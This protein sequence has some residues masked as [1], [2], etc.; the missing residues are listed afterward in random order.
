MDLRQRLAQWPKPFPRQKLGR[1]DFVQLFDVRIDCR[2]DNIPQCPLSQPFGERIDRQHLAGWRRFVGIEPLHARV[3]HFPAS[4]MQRRFTRQKHFLAAREFFQHVRLIEPKRTQIE[5]AV[6]HQHA[7]QRAAG[8]GVAQFAF[9]PR[10]R[11]PKAVCLA[12]D[13]RRYASRSGLDNRAGNKRARRRRC[14][15]RADAITPRAGP[16]PLRNCSGMRSVRGGAVA[17]GVPA[18]GISSTCGSTCVM[19]SSIHL[20]ASQA[21]IYLDSN[22]RRNSREAAKTRRKRR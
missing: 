3:D 16:T 13:R 11:G 6:A 5:P 21:R 4:A 15:D 22:G 2:A 14:S 17:V 12:P 10:C 19:P 1:K 7:Q 9:L 20:F 8:P 18:P